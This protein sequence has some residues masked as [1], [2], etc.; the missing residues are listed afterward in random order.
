[1]ILRV[2]FLSTVRIATH[3]D[4]IGRFLHLI[5]S[6]VEDSQLGK[7]FNTASDLCC[8]PTTYPIFFLMN[9]ILQCKSYTFPTEALQI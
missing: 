5:I 2:F 7:F 9:N 6:L 1:M 8:N 4:V 3:T